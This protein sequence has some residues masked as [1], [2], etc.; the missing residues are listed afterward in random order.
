MI[1]C[2][3]WGQLGDGETYT[4]EGW[5]CSLSAFVIMLEIRSE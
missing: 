1:L 3:Q 4:Q 5:Q 2:G